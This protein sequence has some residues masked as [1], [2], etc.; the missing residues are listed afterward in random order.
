MKRMKMKA[1]DI[2]KNKQMLWALSLVFLLFSCGNDDGTSN[3]IKASTPLMQQIVSHSQHITSVEKDVSYALTDGIQITDASFTYY[4]KPTHMLIAE[5]DLTKSVTLATSTPDDKPSMGG[6]Q[7]VTV[8]AA[9]AEEGGKKVYLGING[10]VYGFY[11]GK[12]NGY[13]SAGVFYKDGKAI[14]DVAADGF[15]NVF[16]VQKDGSV[17]ICSFDEFQSIK[18]NTMQA[19]GGWDRLIANGKAV[20]YSIND[21]N[22]SFHPRTFLGVDEDCRKVLLFVIDGRQPGYSNG[23]RMEDMI[24]VCQGAGCHNAMNLDGGGSTTM[25]YRVEQG[26]KA[27]FEIMNKPS[28]N[29]ARS[30]AN[31][32][33]VVEKK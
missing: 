23:M 22:M 7:Q 8:Q 13:V 4:S 6:L 29:P 33:L 25:V 31:G 1:N 32:L 20:E 26:N 11:S 9:K 10:D 18:D 12:E 28:D 16:C 15:K 17:Q 24:Y 5:I 19:L 30:V 3:D 14:K 21:N 2:I 27:T